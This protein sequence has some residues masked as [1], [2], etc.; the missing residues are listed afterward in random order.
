[1]NATW[2]QCTNEPYAF[3]K[4]QMLTNKHKTS[5]LSQ[6]LEIFGDGPD[7]QDIHKFSAVSMYAAGADTTVASLMVFFLAMMLFPDVLNKAQEELDRVVGDR[8]PNSSDRD[9]LPYIWAIVLEIHRWHPVGPL[10]IPHASIKEDFVRGYRIPKGSII[11]TN[12]WGI[13]HD[14]AMYSDPS[15]F[16]P[17]R[18]IETPKHEAEPDPR[19]YT[20]GFGRRVCPGKLLADNALFVTVAQTLAVFDVEKPVDGNGR[21]VEPKAKFEVCGSVYLS[22]TCVLDIL[23]TLDFRLGW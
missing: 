18:F 13:T 11:M 14:P 19:T 2:L 4:Q 3:V 23:L 7:M 17:E 6:A 22:E 12:I 9:N 8:L 10:G 15:I 5:F 16:R 21:V 1:M 20:F